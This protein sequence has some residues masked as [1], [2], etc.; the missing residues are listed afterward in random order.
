MRERERERERERDSL[1]T[2]T[3]K[4]GF[5]EFPNWEYWTREREGER[6][7]IKYRPQKKLSFGSSNCNW[8]RV[9]DKRTFGQ[10]MHQIPSLISRGKYFLHIYITLNSMLFSYHLQPFMVSISTQIHRL[11]YEKIC[12]TITSH[13][14]A[15]KDWFVLFLANLPISYFPMFVLIAKNHPSK[16]KLSL[17]R[18]HGSVQILENQPLFRFAV[19]LQSTRVSLWNIK[20]WTLC[21]LLES[22]IRYIC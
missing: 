17:S 11:W 5:W 16:E 6:V 13:S 18:V 2:S 3:E 20:L 8:E 14:L 7:C 12:Q 15:C 19:A 21:L 10:A 1:C 22:W 9:L 4:V